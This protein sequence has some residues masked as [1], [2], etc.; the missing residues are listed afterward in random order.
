[1]KQHGLG[2]LRHF[3]RAELEL[4]MMADYHV[5]DKRAQP[6]RKTR[7]VPH[8]VVYHSQRDDH[9]AEE[10]SLGG[11]GEAPIERQLVNLADV[12]EHDA[13]GEQIG[14]YD[15]IVRGDG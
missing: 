1:M 14:I 3:R 12:V 8:L 6:L 11:I 4:T 9:V 7:D 15:R 10:L 5:L 13:G 2:K